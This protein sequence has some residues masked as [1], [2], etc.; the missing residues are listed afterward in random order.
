MTRPGSLKTPPDA[1]KDNTQRNPP[2]LP[3]PDH[4][5]LLGG[6]KKRRASQLDK[7]LRDRLVVSAPSVQFFR[8]RHQYLFILLANT[9]NQLAFLS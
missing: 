7:D 4:V 8:F 6:Q 1:L 3:L 2:L 5:E 9:L